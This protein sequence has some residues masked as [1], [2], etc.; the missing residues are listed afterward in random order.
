MGM[1]KA[2]TLVRGYRFPGIKVTIPADK[3]KPCGLSW[4]ELGK[5]W[6]EGTITREQ[7]AHVIRT[8]YR[9]TKQAE[10]EANERG[11]TLAY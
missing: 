1:A 11:C 8:M 6:S 5:G 7:A 9:R 3:S 10:R 4:H 2:K